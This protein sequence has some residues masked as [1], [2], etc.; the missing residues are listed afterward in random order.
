[1]KTL[2]T[3]IKRPYLR[4]IVAGTKKIEYRQIKPY[5]EKQLANYEPPFLLR[6]INGRRKDAPE[7]TIEVVH[8]EKN[9]RT[10]FYELHLGRVI[11]VQRGEMLR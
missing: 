4:E 5:W 8:V 1:M 6:L 2:T 7:A 3:T 10:G 11:D 9:E